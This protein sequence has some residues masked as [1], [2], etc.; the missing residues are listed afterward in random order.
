[1]ALPA[2]NAPI[3]TPIAIV[4]SRGSWNMWKISDSVEGARVAPA[5]PR[6]GPG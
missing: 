1:M 4:R 5:M 6:A 2:E 3:H